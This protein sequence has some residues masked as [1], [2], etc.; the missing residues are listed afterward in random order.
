MRVHTKGDEDAVA[1]VENAL[2]DL[3]KAGATLVDP[4]PA[5]GAIHRCLAEILPAFD[6]GTLAAVFNIGIAGNAAKLPPDLTLRVIAER[7]APTQGEVLFALNRY[8]REC[9]LKNIGSVADL[10]AK[11]TL[12]PRAPDR[13]RGGAGQR[14]ASRRSRPGPS[15]SPARATVRNWC[16]K[17]R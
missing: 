14:E 9:G 7:E 3:T 17:S 4:G 5:G 16:A 11:S 15:V 8:L 10:I 1:V 2:R 13:R 6:A 12:L